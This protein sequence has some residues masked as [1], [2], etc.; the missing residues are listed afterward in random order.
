MLAKEMKI[1]TRNEPRELKD[2]NAAEPGRG[3]L[4][5]LFLANSRLL[6]VCLGLVFHN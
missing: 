2:F 5:A 1:Q 4:A 3:T 6:F